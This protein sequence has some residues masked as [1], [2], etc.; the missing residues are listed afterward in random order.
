M[1][2]QF[3]VIFK[4]CVLVSR[5][6]VHGTNTNVVGTPTFHRSPMCQ[7]RHAPKMCHLEEIHLNMA[8]MDV[9]MLEA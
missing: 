4:S 9:S 3:V 2:W 7:V 5:I 8:G 1:Y 6:F